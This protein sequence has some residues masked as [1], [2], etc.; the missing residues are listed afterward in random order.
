MLEGRQKNNIETANEEVVHTERSFIELTKQ[1]WMVGQQLP[2]QRHTLPEN[3]QTLLAPASDERLSIS[4]LALASQHDAMLFNLEPPA[5][6][7]VYPL[8]PQ[9][10]KP[11]LPSTLR[12]LF[13]RVMQHAN[14][15]DGLGCEKVIALLSQRGVT[16]HPA[17]WLPNG[18]ED[19]LPDEYLPWVSWSFYESTS[20]LHD[21]L[22]EDNW[23]EWYP[24]ARLQL[25][26]NMRSLHPDKARDLIAARYLGEPADKRLKII[27]VLSI[28]L[29]ERD[30][31]FL[32][33]LLEDRSQKTAR[34]A[35]QFLSRLNHYN[36]AEAVDEEA[37]ELLSFLD[38]SVSGVIKKRIEIRPKSLKSKKQQA[39][40]SELIEKVTLSQLA[41]AMDCSLDTLVE[42]WMFDAF[43]LHDN[44]SF[45][46]SCT[47]ELSGQA[48]QCLLKNLTAYHKKASSDDG[49]IEIISTRLSLEQRESFVQTSLLNHS[50]K[51]GFYNSACKLHMPLR[52]FTFQALKKTPAWKEL[53]SGLKTD[54]TE[55]GYVQAYY[56]EKE[57]AALGIL[58]PNNTAQ[59][60]LE[61][62]ITQGVLRADPVT[63]YL[64]LNIALPE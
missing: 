32:S 17:D 45:L 24:A 5:C 13:R 46:V 49:F 55:N 59:E 60:A 52:D 42:S 36:P 18:R 47:H 56:V 51:L 25:L 57:I 39:I 3:W 27:K 29:N 61:A 11:T 26:K 31:P 41:A 22:T 38:V 40:R 54:L 21:E 16:A 10:S 34:Q 43:R 63:E 37:V 44:A 50:G 14:Q 48:F 19:N 8:L 23:D 1:Q 12:G 30:V 15:H 4:V 2:L 53:V 62:L 35:R 6:S 58:L 33:Q 64:K 9:L 20:S 7:E 28:N